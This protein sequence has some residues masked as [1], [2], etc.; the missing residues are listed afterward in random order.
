MSVTLQEF[1]STPTQAADIYSQSGRFPKQRN[2][3]LVRFIQNSGVSSNTAPATF[4]VKTCER[5]SVTM[6]TVEL[7]QYNK[8]RIVYTG[9]KAEPIRISFYDTAGQTAQ[10]MLAEYTRYYFGDFSQSPNSFRDDIFSQFYDIAGSGFGYTANNGGNPSTNSQWFFQSIQIVHF[11]SNGYDLYTLINP[12]ISSY[13]MDELDYGNAEVATISAQFSYEAV[14]YEPGANGAYGS[15]VPEIQQG[16]AFYGNPLNIPGNPNPI[17]PDYYQGE[18][19]SASG[20]TNNL[21]GEIFG[22][23]TGNGGS[24]NGFFNSS[25]GT[26]L[27]ILGNFIFGANQ[28]QSYSPV[29]NITGDLINIAASRSPIQSPFGTLAAAFTSAALTTATQQNNSAAQL[30]NIA[31]TYGNLNA[32]SPGNVQ[33]G[34]NAG[35]SNAVSYSGPSNSS[36]NQIGYQSS[37]IIAPA[38]SALANE[39]N[40]N[41]NSFSA[42]GYSF[43]PLPQSP[44]NTPSSS[45][46]SNIFGNS[47]I[48]VPDPMTGI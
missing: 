3:F 40:T 16:A 38:G 42:D 9:Y 19:A 35:S 41:A 43:G 47:T 1:L 17:S 34:Y 2:D 23:V 46:F 44:S 28:N 7:N 24:S 11:V 4:V 48:A 12:K 30:N 20:N 36:S 15:S 31:A 25:N 27:G 26:G 29:T 14:L 10:S 13:M 22:A 21:L 45:F 5:P 32:Q 6:N 8:K 33:Y 18:F 37:N 39:L